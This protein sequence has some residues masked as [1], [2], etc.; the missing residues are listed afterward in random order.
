MVN[1]KEKNRTRIISHLQLKLGLHF[2]E[3]AAQLSL[4]VSTSTTRNQKNT[5]QNWP[6]PE[7]LKRPFSSL[8]CCPTHNTTG[9]VHKVLEALQ[10]PTDFS[11]IRMR[12][13]SL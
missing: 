8:F 1:M 6:L 10:L 2:F 7:P 11:F 13:R 4:D 5:Y 9:T 3:W 12:G